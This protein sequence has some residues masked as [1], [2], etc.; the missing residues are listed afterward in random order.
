MSPNP[1]QLLKT[2]WTTALQAS[3]YLTSSWSL[4]KFMS[5]ASVKPSRSLILW[6]PLFHLP[7]IFL[8]IKGFSNE[9]AVCIRWPKFWSFSF[10]VC[11]SSEYSGLI[12]LKIDWFDLAIQGTLRSLLQH[13]FEGISSLMLCLVYGLVLTII[14]NHWGDHSGDY[15]HLSLSAE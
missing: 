6:C 1:V 5:I 8:G 7:S 13:Q 2:P 9:S 15:T 3:L 11:P 10:S 12:S 14:C 4:P